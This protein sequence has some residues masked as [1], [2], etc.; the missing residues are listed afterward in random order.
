MVIRF[1][2]AHL[3]PTIINGRRIPFIKPAAIIEKLKFLSPKMWCENSPRLI[4]ALWLSKGSG[5]SVGFSLFQ[6]LSR[7]LEVFNQP[8]TLVF[9]K[10]AYDGSDGF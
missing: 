10:V 5:R 2:A 9:W 7:P 1:K 8:Q 4:Q 3:E 6:S